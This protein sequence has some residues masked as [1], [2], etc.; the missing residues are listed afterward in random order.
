MHETGIVRNLIRRLEQAAIKA[1][2]DR[3]SAVSIR[4]GALSEFSREHFCAHFCEEA[5][6][7]L[8][9]GAMLRIETSEDIS[10]PHA[11][12]VMIESIT[13]EVQDGGK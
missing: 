13:L 10:D 8:A 9:E 3:V 12:D 1:G 2:S 6:G 5:G 4:L 7:T 11:Q